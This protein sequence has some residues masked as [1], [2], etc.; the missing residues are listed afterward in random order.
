[1]PLYTV[2]RRV[3]AYVCYVASIRAR[4]ARKAAEFASQDE[5]AYSWQEEG[6]DEFDARLFITLDD[7]GHELEET[8]V[9]DF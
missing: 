8:E 1:M 7:E 2:R 4:T 9:G 5:S 6:T 3:D